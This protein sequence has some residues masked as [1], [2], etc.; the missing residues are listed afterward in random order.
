MKELTRAEE[1]ILLTIYRLK[2]NAYGVPI[3]QMIADMTGK[4]YAY[5][6]LYALLDQLAYKE[7]VERIKGE[8]TKERGGRSKTFYRITQPGIDALR[9][10]FELHN[11]IWDGLTGLAKEGKNA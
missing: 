9:K 10:S 4:E 2:D 1:V 5:G 8:P 6:T 3:K 7:Y 11:T